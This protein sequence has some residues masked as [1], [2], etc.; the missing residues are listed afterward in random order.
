SGGGN[1]YYGDGYS[2]SFSGLWAT[3]GLTWGGARAPEQC[4]NCG[5][6]SSPLWRRDAAAGLLCHSC[7]LQQKTERHNRPLLRQ[8]LSRREGTQCVNCLTATTTLWRRNAAGQP[9]CNACGLYYKLHQVNRPLAMKKEGIQTRNRKVTN[10]RKRNRTSGQSQTELCRLVP[11]TEEAMFYSY[12][13]TQL[14]FQL[15]CP[16]VS[17]PAAYNTQLVLLSW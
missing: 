15:L 7:D 5:A 8:T 17:S 1:G 4:G 12:T 2:S 13:H 3:P 6:S 14:P 16:D 11:P 10:N 9:V